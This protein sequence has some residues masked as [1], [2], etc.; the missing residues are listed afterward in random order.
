LI[1]GDQITD[2][3][4]TSYVFDGSEYEQKELPRISV[5]LPIII[6]N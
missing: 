3:V 6:R 5:Y 2:A 1:V 4:K